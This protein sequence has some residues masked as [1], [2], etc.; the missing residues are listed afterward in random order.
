MKP[1]FLLPARQELADAVRYYNAQRAGLGGE[2]ADEARSALG[3][4]VD[5]PFSWHPMGGAIRRC[6]MRRFPY[7]LIYEPWEDRG[8][9]VVIAVANLHQKPDYWRN[10]R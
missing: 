4:I 10:R 7:G 6:Q 5:F 1:R 8:E 3:R 9:I 2:F